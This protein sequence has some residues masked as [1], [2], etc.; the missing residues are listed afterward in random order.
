MGWLAIGGT[1]QRSKRRQPARPI[2]DGL[3]CRQFLS[4]VAA[5]SAAVRIAQTAV[6]TFRVYKAVVQ[7]RAGRVLIT[8]QNAQGGVDPASLENSVLLFRVQ[9]RQFY[10]LTM[11]GTPKVAPGP[12]NPLP[13]PPLAP[14]IQTVAAV[15]Q[16]SIP[17]P[18]G[19]YIVAISGQSVKD[20]AGRQLDGEFRGRFPSG[21][22]VPGSDFVANYPTNGFFEYPP[23]PV[24]AS[25]AGIRRNNV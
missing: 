12:V 3:E 11:I 4:G 19:N 2:V 13:P 21:D 10:P 22:G 1:Q 16:A 23:R 15:F 25:L 24:L 18:A 8:F 17:L 6:P 9:S 14:P 20:A 7:P 5:P